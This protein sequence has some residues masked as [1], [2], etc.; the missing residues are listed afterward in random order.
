MYTIDISG[1][2]A[3]EATT[4]PMVQKPAPTMENYPTPNANSN[5]IERNFSL[6]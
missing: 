1:V 4:H 2:E 5:K 3:R 6:V